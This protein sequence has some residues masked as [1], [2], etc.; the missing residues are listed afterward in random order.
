VRLVTEDVTK[1]K[2]C[3]PLNSRRLQ[4]GLDL[5]HTRIVLAT[6]AQYHA[7]SL[8]WKLSLQDDSVLDIFPLL[9]R[10]PPAPPHHASRQFDRYERI[11]KKVSPKNQLERILEKVQVLRELSPRL[12]QP[13]TEEELC[14]PLGTVCLGSVSPLHLAF[15]YAV[16]HDTLPEYTTPG[17][18]I[19]AITRVGGCHYSSLPRD[20]AIVI[21]TLAGAQVRQ[22]Y[23]LCLLQNYL[24]TL[25]NTLE[26]LGVS[27]ERLG[28]GFTQ[29][30]DQFFASVGEAL[31]RAVVVAMEDTAEEEEATVLRGEEVQV[32]DEEEEEEDGR[33]RKLGSIPLTPPRLDFLLHLLDDVRRFT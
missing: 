6:L 29:F 17:P 7:T 25:T 1:T 22:H 4:A 8:A 30:C 33:D 26:L 10:P 9:S 3:L 5:A 15:Q 16:D 12:E 20:L 11:I 31:A 19:A 23:L 13:C 24:I 32:E 18:S 21:F 27:W 2:A 28:V 14:D